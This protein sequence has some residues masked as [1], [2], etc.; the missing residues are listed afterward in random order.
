[1]PQANL[2]YIVAMELWWRT[3]ALQALLAYVQ[4]GGQVAWAL[5]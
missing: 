1:M 2:D 3:A 4:V 5:V